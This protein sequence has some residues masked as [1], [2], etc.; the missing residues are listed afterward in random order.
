[1]LL[2]NELNYSNSLKRGLEKSTNS[3]GLIIVLCL[4]SI[5]LIGLCAAY[6]FSGRIVK[7]IMEVSKMLLTISKGEGDLTQNLKIREMDEIGYLS[8]HFND[9]IAALS[10]MIR[11]IKK[12]SDKT[13]GI[14]SNLSLS[15]EHLTDS[16]GEIKITIEKIGEKI[17]FLDN[18]IL[19]STDLS[20]SARRLVS[21]LVDLMNTQASAIDQSS[22]SIEQM[23]SAIRNLAKNS[24]IKYEMSQK[25]QTTAERGDKMME[26]MFDLIKKISDSATII[27]DLLKVINNT[28]SQTNLLAMNAA[29][30]AAHAGEYGKGFSVVADEIRKLATNT[31]ASAKEISDSL[32]E[33]IAFM[34]MSEES[35]G[36]TSRIF[37]EMVSGISDVS[38]SMVEM[39]NAMGEMS[40]GSEQ[41]VTSLSSLVKLTEDVKVSYSNI[42][43]DIFK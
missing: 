4:V 33:L 12:V 37:K 18:E 24:E 13:K 22:A 30:E 34:Q 5:G 3:L 43:S 11:Q 40:T 26:D 25:L 1:M 35:T 27:D 7:P 8:S 15:A 2:L 17:A 42:D 38:E 41:I 23:M 29:I 21:D 32:K 16:L 10:L 31:S 28:A 20:S 19:K 39:K 6:V 36:K 14:G 9:F